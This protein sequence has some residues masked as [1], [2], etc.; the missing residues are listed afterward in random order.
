MKQKRFLAIFVC[1]AMIVC[2]LAGCNAEQTP[3]LATD[4]P[5]ESV[6]AS[7]SV[8][9][10]ATDAPFDRYAHADVDDNGKCDDCGI[11]VL[12][13]FDFYAINDLHGKFEDSQTQGGVDELTTY[14]RSAYISDTNAIFLSS[15]DMWQ[16]SYE[17]NSTRGMIITDWMNDLDFVSMT[18]GNHEYDWGEEYIEKN[19]EAAE[20]PFLAINVYEKETGERVDY[21]RSSVLIERD[22]IK[23][24]I[25]GAIG[26]CY[27]SISGEMVED[28][29]FKTGSE[30]T[31]LVKA[32]SEKLRAEG[33]DIVV[34]S[35][36]DGYG[37]SMDTE[38]IMVKDEQIR[39]YYDISLSDGYVDLVFEGHTHASYVLEDSKGVYHLQNG[40]D[41]RGISHAE[42]TLN[43]ANGNRVVTEAE[44]VK[45]GV[46]SAYKGDPIVDELMDKY[47]DKVE[48]GNEV[49]G[50]CGRYRDART[51]CQLVADLYYEVGVE[52]WGEKYELALG[53]GFI[54][55]RSPKSISVGDVTYS[56][57]AMLFPFDN[58]LVLCSVKGR[59]LQRKFF[60]TNNSN[61]YIAYG[62]YG[63]E[64]RKNID[65]NATYYI[66][67]D[68][69]CSSYAYNNLTVVDYYDEGVFARDLVADYIRD[70]RME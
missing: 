8:S 57:L 7:E 40:G 65:P 60:E 1:L 61:Y 32:E 66:V 26:D 27:S 51:L 6:S 30:L 25:I 62:E 48:S 52:R 23:V 3:P 39:S 9:E 22:G 64:L 58:R 29:Y 49:L 13:A 54:S 17:S 53:G 4:A 5:S 42:I 45:H 36:H 37:K 11:S 69:Y 63:E 31:A 33:A 28:I 46:Y 15:G 24:G 56:Q 41:N 68:T 10:S 47:A 16:G 2:S 38:G 55:I 12:V 59:D 20:F 34:Y 67:T 14:L 70:G 50:S 35:L 44:F 19:A 43:F 21:C 18:L